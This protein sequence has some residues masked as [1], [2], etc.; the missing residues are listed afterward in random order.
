MKQLEKS[1]LMIEKLEEENKALKEKLDLLDSCL[2]ILFDGVT[3]LDTEGKIAYANKIKAE[4]IGYTQEELIG[5]KPIQIIAERDLQRYINEF[6]RVLYNGEIPRFF[7][8][9]VKHK[10]GKEIPMEISFSILHNSKGEV[11]GAVGASR[12]ITNERAITQ[13]LIESEEKYRVIFESTGTAMLTVSNSEI[14]QMVNKDFERLFG[15]SKEE[16]VGKKKLTDFMKDNTPAEIEASHTYPKRYETEFLNKVGKKINLIVIENVLPKNSNSA[17]NEKVV[18]LIDVTENKKVMKEMEKYQRQLKNLSAHLQDVIE[19]DRRKLAHEIH[20][21]FGQELTGLK[22]QLS[23]LSEDPYLRKKAIKCEINSMINLVDN[24]MTEVK[25]TSL[26]LSPIVLEHFG[27]ESAIK[28]LIEDFQKK[29]NIQYNLK[30]E[31]KHNLP[32]NYQLSLTVFRI[33]QE[34][35]TNTARHSRATQV[36]IVFKDIDNS[37]YL[38]FQDN[39]KGIPKNKIF[40][41]NSFGLLGIRERVLYQGGTI[42][43][44]SK[45]NK[46]T[47]VVITMPLPTDILK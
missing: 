13:K 32:N 33:L 31:L 21:S 22:I 44:T 15:Y 1:D 36:N 9:T 16:V 6:E 14:I 38:E 40:S 4:R 10:S 39:G 43:I 29:T 46:E 8:Y 7:E 18:A 2:D 34:L 47:R 28:W 5:I 19:E 20:D 11:I 42:N 37:L 25:D 26:S 12:D 45:K 27:F 35:M 23:L 30:Y 41:L 3:V 24:I 17:E